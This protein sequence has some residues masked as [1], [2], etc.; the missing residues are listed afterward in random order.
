V[1]GVQF[2]VADRGPGTGAR[3]AG[4]D[5]PDNPTVLNAG[6]PPHRVRRV[7]HQPAQRRDRRGRARTAYVRGKHPGA[8]TRS[9]APYPSIGAL[10]RFALGRIQEAQIL[11]ICHSMFSRDDPGDAVVLR[12]FTIASDQGQGCGPIDLLAALA[13]VEG[14][15][16]A[17]CWSASRWPTTTLAVAAAALNA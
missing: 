2:K 17:R 14:P 10:S 4:S 16:T 1:R 3:R 8:D 11:Q 5:N 12:A 15:V 7:G 6:H 9:C 13:E